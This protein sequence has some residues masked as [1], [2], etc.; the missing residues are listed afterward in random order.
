MR[1]TA[2]LLAIAAFACAYSPPVVQA[3]DVG[4]H[5]EAVVPTTIT[6]VTEIA[7]T[8]INISDVIQIKATS[9]TVQAILPTVTNKAA[10]IS[11]TGYA[12]DQ[13]VPY[14]ITT[15]IKTDRVFSFIGEKY[16]HIDPGLISFKAA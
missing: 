15:F 7:L 5:Y 1:K 14:G 4:I 16:L 9:L 10:S 6:Q 2:F 12:I 13:R 8:N 3:K 11:T